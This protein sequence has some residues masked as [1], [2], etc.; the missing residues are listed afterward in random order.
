MADLRKI[1]KENYNAIV[2][3]IAWVVIYKE[4]KSWNCGY[5]YPEGGS[6]DEGYILSP[7]DTEKLEDISDRDY[8]AIC[9]NG[10]YM[11]F[12]ED[13]TPKEVADKV[14]WMYENRRNQLKGDFIDGF[15]VNKE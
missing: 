1:I 10:Y 8:K 7:E 2:E 13:N 9:I 3:G 5:F 6:Y 14:L 15:V 11:G 12:G 4:G